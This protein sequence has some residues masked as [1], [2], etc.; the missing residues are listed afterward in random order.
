M[1]VR[2]IR[3]GLMII[4][5]LMGV[6]ACRATFNPAT[7]ADMDALFK[8][9]MAQYNGKHYDNSAKAFERLTTELPARDPRVP[10]SFFYLAKSQE[11]NGEKLLAC[12]IV[13]PHLRAVS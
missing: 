6:A 7:Y 1:K 12:E 4:A 8:A 2:R 10:I 13:Q 11:K 5:G 9:A 3:A